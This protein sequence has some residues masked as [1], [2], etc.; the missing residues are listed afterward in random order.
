M[1]ERAYD[2]DFLP[3]LAELPSVQDFSSAEKIQ[4]IREM[5][6]TMAPPSPDRDD[7][8]MPWVAVEDDAR[9]RVRRCSGHDRQH[10]TRRAMLAR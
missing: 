3:L 6:E 8:V 1:T 5:R 9:S 7:V 10:R 2:R 4:E